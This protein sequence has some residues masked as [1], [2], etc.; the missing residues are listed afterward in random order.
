MDIGVVIPAAGRGKRMQA[1]RNKMFLQLAGHPVLRHTVN[2]FYGHCTINNIILVAAEDEI[3]L[4]R[5]KIVE[6]YGFHGVD[7]VRGGSTRRQSVFSGLQALKNVDSVIV[8]DGARPLLQKKVLQKVIESLKKYDAV[9][10]GRNLK[11]AVK[12]RDENNFVRESLDRE[13]LVA[14]ST[15]QA[16]DYKLLMSAHKQ[17]SCDKKI[18]DDASLVEELGERVKI[19]ED[20]YNNIKI[21]TPMDLEVA[22][23]IFANRREKD[24]N[25]NWF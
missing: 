21:T 1:D 9:T 18:Y 3:D 10:A 7:V 16:F 25:G 14:V 12:V 22:E 5:E 6:K 2:I 19:I 24:E 13:K 4:C 17:V 23:Y 11:D 8:H 20:T 15:P